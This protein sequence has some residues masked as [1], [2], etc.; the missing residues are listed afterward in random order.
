ME[1][2]GDQILGTIAGILILPDTGKIEGF[3]V[4]AQGILGVETVFCSTVDIVRWGTRVYVNSHTALAPAEDRIRLQSLL[5]DPR[6]VLNQKIRTE[7][8]THLG[9]CKDVQF[10]TESMHIE[11][12]FPKKWFRWGVALPVSDIV[13]ITPEAIITKDPMKKQ[14]IKEQNKE[15]MSAALPDATVAQ[16]YKNTLRK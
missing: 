2:G 12:L 8:G 10:N 16:T 14:Y 13:E 7:A 9:R 15:L 5:Q 11:W 3:F 4:H 1:E 6:T